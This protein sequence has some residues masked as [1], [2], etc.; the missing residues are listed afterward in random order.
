M[1]YIE[2]LVSII[3]FYL[4]ANIDGTASRNVNWSLSSNPEG[5]RNTFYPMQ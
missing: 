4:V 2:L 1:M 3:D 5:K